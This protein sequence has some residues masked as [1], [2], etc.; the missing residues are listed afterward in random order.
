MRDCVLFSIVA[1]ILQKSRIRSMYDKDDMN[2][3]SLAICCRSRFRFCSHDVWSRFEFSTNQYHNISSF[4][5]FSINHK[6]SFYLIILFHNHILVDR[7]LTLQ[8]LQHMFAQILWSL[9][10]SKH[11]EFYHNSHFWSHSHSFHL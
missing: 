6:K 1:S 11:Q 3:E 8:T 5:R 4:S 2:D 10:T 9:L 7:M